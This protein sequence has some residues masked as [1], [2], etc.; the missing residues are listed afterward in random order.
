MYKLEDAIII[1][2]TGRAGKTSTA[3]LVHEYLKSLG[4]KS[5]LYSSCKVDSP[6]GQY[7]DLG[8]EMTFNTEYDVIKILHEA[9]AYEAEYII[10]ECWETS[11]K[12]GFFDKI[13]FDLKVMTKFFYTGNGHR[14]ADLVYQNKLRFFKDEQDAK[15]LINVVNYDEPEKSQIINFIKEANVKDLVLMDSVRINFNQ[16]EGVYEDYFNNDSKYADHRAN[17]KASDIKYK[18]NSFFDGANKSILNIDLAGQEL[19]LTSDLISGYHIEN[20]M[21][22]AAILNEINALDIESFKE[23]IADPLLEIPGRMESIQWEGRTILIDNLIPLRLMRRLAGHRPLKVIAGYKV[24]ESILDENHRKNHPYRPGI[25]GIQDFNS[26]PNIV[27]QFADYV[28]ITVTNISRY[29]AE[30]LT[31]TFAEKTTI[32][33]TKILNRAEAIKVALEESK[34]GDVIAIVKRGSA[35][36]FLDSYDKFSYFNDSETVYDIIDKLKLQKTEE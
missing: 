5:I 31:D 22:A 16:N 1:G 18:L 9:V 8:M 19:P 3:Y 13:P 33:Y 2:I 35:T 7:G 32:P 24:V 27:N 29:S 26:D 12:N 15:C 21:V 23:F 20:I 25:D 6:Y 17:F 28:Y 34:P 14:G 30:F 36:R 4:K 11:I 10:I